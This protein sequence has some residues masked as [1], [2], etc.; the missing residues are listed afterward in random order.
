MSRFP[1]AAENPSP[2]QRRQPPAQRPGPASSCSCSSSRPS[3][4]G[5]GSIIDPKC[6]GIDTVG[7]VAPPPPAGRGSAFTFRGVESSTCLRHGS[8]ASFSPAPCIALQG[9]TS[10]LGQTASSP[11]ANPQ[12]RSVPLPGKPSSSAIPLPQPHA[13]Q[14][15]F[16][17]QED[18]RFQPQLRR[19]E[20]PRA[21]LWLRNPVRSLAAG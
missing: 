18:L 14:A 13:G 21:L 9:R 5:K 11:A 19:Q 17:T 1:L 3:G 7:T 12:K 2:R 8:V 6:I 20:N 16:L 10:R 15:L 4:P